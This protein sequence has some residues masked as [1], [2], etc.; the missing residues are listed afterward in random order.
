MLDSEEM[1]W[2]GNE[3]SC[4]VG[5]QRIDVIPSVVKE[6]Q[7]VLIPMELKSV[8]ANEKNVSQIQ[9]YVD[10][11]RQYYIPN[12][13]S[14]IQPILL[15]KKINKRGTISYRNL[16]DSFH[17]FNEKNNANCEPLKFIEFFLRHNDLQFEL[18]SY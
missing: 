14:D 6:K 2:L 10:W 5:M 8:E 11:I 13:P 15:A 3:V 12:R 7:R 9:R 16:I 18:V 17:R 4:G 1:E